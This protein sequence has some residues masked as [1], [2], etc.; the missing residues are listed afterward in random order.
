MIWRLYP[1]AILLG[2]A[3]STVVTIVLGVLGGVA[4]AVAGLDLSDVTVFARIDVAVALLFMAITSFVTGGYAAARLAPGEEV[5]NAIATGALLLAAGYGGPQMAA[6]PPW[7]RVSSIV[8]AL[9]SALA[10]GLLY[11]GRR[12]AAEQAV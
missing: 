8:L 3:A 4:S 7:L 6:L 9:P 11:R 2:C 5:V 10:G 1:F 12:S